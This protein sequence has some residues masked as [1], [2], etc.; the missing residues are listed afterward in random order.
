MV[1]V[2][3]AEKITG[4]GI[5]KAQQTLVFTA[6][7]SHKVMHLRLNMK[8]IQQSFR[9]LDYLP[10]LFNLFGQAGLTSLDTVFEG[11]SSSRMPPTRGKAHRRFSNNAMTKS[12]HSFPRL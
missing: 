2:V 1:E 10:S 3:V 5:Y 9:T 6:A 7:Q 11:V 4:S 12:R 8:V